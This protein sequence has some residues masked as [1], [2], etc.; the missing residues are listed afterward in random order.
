[1]VAV[2]NRQ[3]TTKKIQRKLRLQSF[4]FGTEG[5]LDFDDIVTSVWTCSDHLLRIDRRRLLGNTK[6]AREKSVD[7]INELN[8]DMEEETRDLQ[9]DCL[10]NYLRI[11]QT[12]PENLSARE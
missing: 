10:Y 1:V 2:R 6:T 12:K 9:L 5:L 11:G 7:A 4:L 3:R 8:A